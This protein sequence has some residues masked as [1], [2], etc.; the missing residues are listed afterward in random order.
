MTVIYQEQ[1]QVE[2]HSCDHSFKFI[3]VLVVLWAPPLHPLLI[4]WLC[5][6]V[7]DRGVEIH[8]MSY[9]NK[10]LLAGFCVS[11]VQTEGFAPVLAVSEWV[12]IKRGVWVYEF[13][14]CWG[15]WAETKP[16][17]P[18]QSILCPFPLCECTLG[19]ISQNTQVCLSTGLGEADESHP[20][21]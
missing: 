10:Y 17:R 19:D 3:M 8:L 7:Y 18:L 16:D 13:I 5:E 14:L 12:H 2:V 4:H 21:Q 9:G 15:Q 1:T 6:A 11:C 20:A